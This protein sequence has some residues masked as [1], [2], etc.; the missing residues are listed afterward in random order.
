[1]AI[2]TTPIAD[3]TDPWGAALRASLATLSAQAVDQFG[4][5]AKGDLLAGTAN[6][7]IA[8]IGVG[9]DGT[10]LTA[11]SAQT[12]GLSWVTPTGGGGGGTW[13]SITGTLSSQ[14]DLNTALGLKAPLASPALTGTP[15]APTASTAT[16][17]TQ[18]ATTA[19]V[20]AQAYATLASPTLTGTPVAPTATAGTN[21]TQ[22]ATT[23]FVTTAV[24]GGGGGGGTGIP[25]V[26]PKTSGHVLHVGISG[27][28]AAGT[29]AFATG[30]VYP[31]PFIIGPTGFTTDALIIRLSTAETGISVRAMIYSSDTDGHPLTLLQSG[32][33]STTASTGNYTVP[34]GANLALTAGLYWVVVRTNAGS[35]IRFTSIAPTQLSTLGYLGG[36][37]SALDGSRTPAITFDPG[38][39]ASP[40]TTITA[41]TWTSITTSSIPWVGIRKA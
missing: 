8:R 2:T 30:D 29:S 31:L 17:T 13:G 32:T 40:T 33:V 23:A 1:M 35:T 27:A 26:Q 19:Y 14:T 15:T 12:T 9:A 18:V 34:L 7:T 36:V 38:T 10:V 16:N 11:D 21:T 37:A 22:L 24:A 25:T 4:I 3:G 41:W 28:N 20:K 5:N 39:Y 6:D